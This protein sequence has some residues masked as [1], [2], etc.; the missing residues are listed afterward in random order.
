MLAT[1][2]LSAL[3]FS[4]PLLPRTMPHGRVA[5]AMSERGGENP[6]STEAIQVNHARLTANA[7]VRETLT[8]DCM[9]LCAYRCSRNGVQRLT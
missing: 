7:S 2:T 4:A 3:C 9:E 5:L 1:A 8:F 6:L